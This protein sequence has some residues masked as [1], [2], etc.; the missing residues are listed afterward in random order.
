M[1][2]KRKPKWPPKYE[3]EYYLYNFVKIFADF[4][5]FYVI[6]Q[7]FCATKNV[8]HVQNNEKA[9][10]IDLAQVCLYWSYILELDR[11]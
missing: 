6:L 4:Y 1:S 8:G 3:D 7:V 5:D 10:Y 2:Q 9:L 11:S